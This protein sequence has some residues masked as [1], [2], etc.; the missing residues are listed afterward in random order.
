MNDEE[1]ILWRRLDLPGHEIAT[2]HRW[3]DEW[4]VSGVAVFVESGSPC[5]IEYEIRCDARWTTRGCALQGAIGAQ[6]VHVNIEREV[7]GTWSVNG[8]EVAELHGCADIDLGFS[9]VTNLL[10]IRRLALPIGGRA[11]VGAA[12]VRFPELSVE[13]LEQ[14]YTR[15]A[16]DRY[17][18]ESAGGNFRRVLTVNAFGC[19]ID[20][21]G[22]WLAEATTSSS[23]AANGA[24]TLSH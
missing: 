12:W 23:L 11:S 15:A 2:I 17:E 21:P 1:I 19:V 5:R 18:Y 8:D 6:A 3:L 10:P 22:L 13:V 4:R 7:G 20:Y 24:P 14:T 16:S 9:P